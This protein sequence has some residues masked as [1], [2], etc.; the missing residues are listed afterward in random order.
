MS[1]AFLLLDFGMPPQFIEYILAA[2]GNLYGV[3]RS[4][5]VQILIFL[6]ALQAIPGSL[7]EVAQIEGATA[8]ESFWK[9]T[10]PMVSPLTLTNVVYT[11][12]DAFAQ[13]TIVQLAYTT[14]FTNVNFGLSSAMS[15]TSAAVALLFLAVV[16]FAISRYVYYQN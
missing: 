3:I 8:Y 12:V 16:S 10:I 13:S 9:I 4:S 2:I 1:V 14:A 15:L 5:G 11:I 7:Y 6:A